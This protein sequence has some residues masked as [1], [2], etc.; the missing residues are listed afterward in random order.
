VV[1]SL[2]SIAG[3]KILNAE[4][5]KPRVL[6]GDPDSSAAVLRGRTIQTIERYGKFLVFRLSP[7]GFLLV[8]LGMTGKLLIDAP[9]TKHSHVIFTLDRGVLQ[10]EDTRQFGR[11][12]I[13]EELPARIT[14]LGP[15]ALDVDL[16]TFLLLLRQRKTRMKA[17]LLNQEF[18]RGLGNI[19]ADEALFRAGIHPLA[20]SL[21][22]PRAEKLYTAIREVLSEAIAAK[23][24]SISDY[25]DSEGKRGSFQDRHRVYQRTGQPCLICGKPIKRTLVAQRGTH[26][27]PNCQKR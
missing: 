16:E 23:G 26:F 5:R 8:H 17:L 9:L 11:V 12:E 25:V 3:R 15:D 7:G 19:Y 4:F 20:K 24:S 22:R 14:K 2:Q 10:Y 13:C 6:Q 21:K 1:R 18:L 27:C